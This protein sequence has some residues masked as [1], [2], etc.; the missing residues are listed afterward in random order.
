MTTTQ[1]ISNRRGS[2][3]GAALLFAIGLLALMIMLCVS[4]SM[5]SLQSQKM[6]SN[7][8]SR[9]AAKVLAQSA[10]RHI[11]S[12]VL[13]YCDQKWDSASVDSQA[14]TNHF[15]TDLSFL[16]SR[17]KT[18][19]DTDML[20]SFLPFRTQFFESKF[21]EDGSTYKTKF[22]VSANK[23][24][25][26]YVYGNLTG[27]T[28]KSIVGRYAYRVRPAAS[29]TQVNL[30][31]FLSG[32][33]ALSS[34]DAGGS[35]INELSA[36]CEGNTVSGAGLPMELFASLSSN[37][38]FFK[39]KNGTG[40]VTSR[41]YDRMQRFFTD[42]KFPADIEVFKTANSSTPYYYHRYNLKQE[43]VVSG[44]S[45]S[46]KVSSLVDCT[47]AKSNLI[48]F[49]FDKLTAA[50]LA[51]DTF[52]K[53][54]L[55]SS[56]YREPIAS[57]KTTPTT[58][59]FFLGMIADTPGAFS[60]KLTR[61]KQIAANF[62][63]YCDTDSKPTSDV[64][65]A[66]WKATA[67]AYTGNEK[68]L[69]INEIGIH[70]NVK[71]AVTAQGNAISLEVTPTFLAELIDIY[72][73]L[74][75]NNYKLSGG[76]KTLKFK[77]NATVD[78]LEKD[79]EKSEP[80]LVLNDIE[81][82]MTFT[83][84]DVASFT[85]QNSGY[86]AGM[87]PYAPVSNGESIKFTLP[88]EYNGYKITRYS[89]T[90]TGLS[91]SFSKTLVLSDGANNVDCVN[92]GEDDVTV[93]T[94]K[95]VG[96]DN[97]IQ[98]I[99]LTAEAPS[100]E[101]VI[102]NMAAKDPRQNLNV[103]FAENAAKETGAADDEGK[104]G[105]GWK[106]SDWVFDPAVLPESD[107]GADTSRLSMTLVSTEGVVNSL[108]GKCN[109]YSNPSKPA[110]S[111]TDFA[112]DST[113]NDCE[114]VSDPAC[115]DGGTETTTNRISTAY[116]RDGVMQSMWELGFIHRGAAWET[117]NLLGSAV[118]PQD[119]Y[120]YIHGA[121]NAA[122]GSSGFGGTDYASG[123]AAILDTVKLS[124]D[125]VS[126]GM[127]DV[128][129]LRSAAPGYDYTGTGDDHKLFDSLVASLTSH[130]TPEKELETSLF[131]AKPEANS[132]EEND[133]AR[134]TKGAENADYML[135]RSEFAGNA[136]EEV[137]KHADTKFKTDAAREEV[138]GKLM[139]LL[140][141]SPALVT[142]FHA[143][144]VVQTIKDIG[145]VEVAKLKKD[146]TLTTPANTTLG[147]L[148]KVDLGSETVYLDDIT[149]QLKLRATFDFNPYT[150]KVKLRQ[151]KYLD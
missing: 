51:E 77:V 10:I 5:E 34:D 86:A 2:E 43:P 78:E 102:G 70:N 32:K 148:D 115:A 15:L 62:L 105:S 99:V 91:V 67:P 52:S 63:D 149:G 23:P 90:V 124:K 82:P 95:Y 48:P 17:D 46:E 26:V 64:D 1:I 98:N 28:T 145:G 141:A 133:M 42:G 118:T 36:L 56:Y 66:S 83:A 25:W 74:N 117:V 47:A 107:T 69:Y 92:I 35:Y 71:T 97:A 20:D 79:G 40:T 122:A 128:N 55:R 60:N 18:Q 9:S 93:S 126:W 103:K 81:I 61:R 85:R 73:G 151:I 140:K 37:A 114:I 39:E 135:A 8:S 21:A 44:N 146:G 121:H 12:A 38:K 41:E 143:D 131:P 106:K 150:G 130:E 57:G 120:N 54:F 68:T 14:T 144:I 147:T 111:G 113:N 134:L 59:L 3:R 58:N 136:L 116:I 84:L 137:F 49:S 100:C 132:S 104:T 4:F 19:T 45:D 88:D 22:D 119:I 27:G 138:V 30:A 80:G 127:I 142:V 112:A 108:I 87:K 24:N 53:K 16:V 7:N 109:K 72:G 123:D 6:A 31:Y 75:A 110:I 96:A 101:L 94:D 65:P 50:T 125:A 129:M 89:V 139:P 76:M 13:Y 29:S 33:Q 11:S